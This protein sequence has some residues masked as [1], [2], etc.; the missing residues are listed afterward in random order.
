MNRIRKYFPQARQGPNRPSG[1]RTTTAMMMN[2]LCPTDDDATILLLF[3]SLAEINV[4]L[5][6]L[7]SGWILRCGWVDWKYVAKPSRAISEHRGIHTHFYY[8]YSI[9][10]T[11]GQHT[12][13]TNQPSSQ[14]SKHPWT[15][16]KEQKS[17]K[18][19]CITLVAA[20]APAYYLHTEHC[21]CSDHSSPHNH[22]TPNSRSTPPASQSVK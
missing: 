10:P 12:T 1:R 13:P 19:K 7:L 18:H 20:A 3:G 9:T 16:R 15:G 22:P 2:L 6:V 4:L 17:V 8:M 14:P 5:L 11:P 21:C